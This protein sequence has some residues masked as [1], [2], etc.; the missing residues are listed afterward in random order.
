MSSVE[1]DQRVVLNTSLLEL[2]VEDGFAESSAALLDSIAII[3]AAQQ[4]SNSLSKAI[5]K[6][7][8]SLAEAFAN[9]PATASAAQLEDS[10]EALVDVIY[11]LEKKNLGDAALTRQLGEVLRY[12]QSAWYLLLTDSEA[13]DAN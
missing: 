5:E 1:G 3:G 10:I 8:E 4:G 13:D 7:E 2:E 12:Y 11:E 9:D 6:I